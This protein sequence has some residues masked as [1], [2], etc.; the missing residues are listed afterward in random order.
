MT[1]T[2]ANFNELQDS[3]DFYYPTFLPKDLAI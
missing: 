3:L 2:Y 1:T